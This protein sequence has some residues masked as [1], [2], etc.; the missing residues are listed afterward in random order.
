MR[1]PIVLI[2]IFILTAVLGP[3]VVVAGLLGIEEKPG[4]VY[5]WCIH[6]WCRAILRISG[7][8]VV[9]HGAEK[10]SATRGVVYIAN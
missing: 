4:G 6:T 7:V 5:Q 8:K 9:V 1:S 2:G 10:L 3:V